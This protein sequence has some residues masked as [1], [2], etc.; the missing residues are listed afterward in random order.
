MKK[1]IRVLLLCMLVLTLVACGKKG[2][3]GDSTAMNENDNP[4]GQIAT[5]TPEPEPR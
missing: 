2:T 5:Q 3:D 1:G 4:K